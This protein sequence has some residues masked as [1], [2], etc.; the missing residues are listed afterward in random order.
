M[1]RP[2]RAVSGVKRA[3]QGS[4]ASI[5][6]RGFRAGKVASDRFVGDRESGSQKA[7]PLTLAAAARESS[8]LP[9][10]VPP[11][12]SFP[13]GV[14]PPAT[15]PSEPAPFSLPSPGPSLAAGARY[16]RRSH[17]HARS[18]ITLVICLPGENARTRSMCA[19]PW[20]A[21]CHWQVNHRSRCRS[22]SPGTP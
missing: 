7:R 11:P 5:G 8:L 2:S 14:C 10:V 9:P 20:P 13:I 18:R 12:L 3:R 1:P 17:R 6:R 21:L 22:A 16:A 15:R 19:H 4:A